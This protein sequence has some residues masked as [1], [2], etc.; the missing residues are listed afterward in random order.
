MVEAD[1]QAVLVGILLPREVHQVALV[2]HRVA[3]MDHQKAMVDHQ[4]ASMDH[5][6]ELVDHLVSSTGPWMAGEDH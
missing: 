6:V 2:D 3:S 4:F 5:Q 1:I